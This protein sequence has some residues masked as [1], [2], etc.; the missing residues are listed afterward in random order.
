MD[1]TRAMIPT[2]PIGRIMI[3]IRRNSKFGNISLILIKSMF[4]FQVSRKM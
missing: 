2:S 4:L 3:Q 1:K